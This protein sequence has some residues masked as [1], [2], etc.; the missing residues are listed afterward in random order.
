MDS[1]NTVSKGIK[2]LDSDTEEEDC[3]LMI[4]ASFLAIEQSIGEGN[5]NETP[6]TQQTSIT[7]YFAVTR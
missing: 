2:P 4:F 6:P 7:H 5:N 3:G 1:T